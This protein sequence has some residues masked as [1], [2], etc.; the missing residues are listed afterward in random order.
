MR[1]DQQWEVHRTPADSIRT[2]V[3][4]LDGLNWKDIACQGDTIHAR[5]G[6]RLL[7]RL[8]GALIRSGAFPMKASIV[9]T[10]SH[11]GTLINMTLA[12]DEGWYAFRLP[13]VQSM[14]E[15]AAARWFAAVQAA[16][17]G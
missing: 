8:F 13:V 2:I 5:K 11:S 9:A 17:K 4:T 3:T 1:A 6:S 14:F 7:L 15:F 16:T 10:P 12:S